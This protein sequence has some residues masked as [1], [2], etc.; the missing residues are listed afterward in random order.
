MCMN[1]SLII[2]KKD[3]SFAFEENIMIFD[4]DGRIVNE[5]HSDG[6]VYSIHWDDENRISQVIDSAGFKTIYEYLTEGQVIEHIFYNNK[7]QTSYLREKEH[8]Q[9]NSSDKVSTPEITLKSELALK[10]SQGLID[11]SVINSLES[12]SNSVVTPMSPVVDYYV[13]GKRMN[14]LLSSADF[15][16]VNGSAMTESQIQSFLEGKNSVLKDNIKIYAI[17]SNGNAYDT[18]RIVKPSK[19]I[20]DAAKDNNINPKVILV[21]LQKEGSIV[22]STDPDVNRRAF[23]YA[24]GYGATDGGDITTYTGF[25]KQVQLASAWM[26]DKWL[27]D[28]ELY[29]FMTVHD[30]VTKTSGGVTY[31]GQIQV[32]TFSAWVLYKYTP[33]VIDTKLLPKIGGGNYLFLK[34]FEGW[35]TSWY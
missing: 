28:A 26:Y 9:I 7:K 3:K 23:H 6:R 5:I 14:S 2:L 33:H 17:N 4:E 34:V 18:G 19:V 1:R 12:S 35:W 10:Y 24:M 30:G 22:T 15:L 16:Y 31:Q 11:G 25:D 21:Q 13:D 8:Y 32:D 27:N 29:V 20:S